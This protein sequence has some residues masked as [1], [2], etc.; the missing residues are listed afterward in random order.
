VNEIDPTIWTFSMKKEMFK[1]YFW[2][3]KPAFILPAGI[4][5]NTKFDKGIHY[6][7]HIFNIT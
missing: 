7:L 3:E 2:P 1:K 5:N 4:F 6:T